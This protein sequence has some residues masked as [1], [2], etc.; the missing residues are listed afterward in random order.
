MSVSRS[1]SPRVGKK[2]TRNSHNITSPST[3]TDVRSVV[4]K[5]L[6]KCRDLPT[7]D[8]FHS[9]LEELKSENN[10]LRRT[11]SDGYY[12]KYK[13]CHRHFTNKLAIFYRYENTD[14][15]I[16]SIAQHTNDDNQWEFLWKKIYIM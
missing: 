14:L 11:R 1:F 6:E 5:W 7:I 13:A 4:E 9:E 15:H 2:Q 3:K 8:A 16:L 10:R 12:H